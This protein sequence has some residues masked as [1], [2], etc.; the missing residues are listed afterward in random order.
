VVVR[1]RCVWTAAVWVAL[2]TAAGVRVAAAAMQWPVVN[3]DEATLGL[4][5]WHIA[6][7]RQFP[8]FFY[9]QHY[10]GS[11]VAY[12]AAPVFWLAGPSPFGL[13][14]VTIA[15][16]L[17]FLAALWKLAAALYDRRVASISVWVLAFGSIPM[18]AGQLQADGHNAT[19]LLAV[20]VMFLA[21][22]LGRAPQHDLARF[23]RRRWMW[24]GWGLVAGFGLW[25]DLLLV[26]FLGAA[27]LVLLAC[28]RSGGRSRVGWAVGG[29]L[30]GIGPVIGHSLLG[31]GA[32]TVDEVLG[33]V[34]GQA[35][36]RP[37]PSLSGRLWGAV[38]VSLPMATGASALCTDGIAPVWRTPAL[39]DIPARQC[40]HVYGVW[41]L[42]VLVLLLAALW[43]AARGAW[44][45]A[46]RGAMRDDPRLWADAAARLAVIGAAVATLA[47]YAVSS[48]AG[49]S[50]HAGSRYLQ[51]TWVG[52]PAV[53]AACISRG[54]ASAAG[55]ERN[56]RRLGVTVPRS[57]VGVVLCG[58]LLLGTG[59]LLSYAGQ[60]HPRLLQQEALR[61]GLLNA[62]VTRLYTDYW[63][64]NAL[65]FTSRE[66]IICAV[67]DD[68][69]T[70]G[71][72]R[73]RSYPAQVARAPG[74]WYVFRHD[75]AAATLL[76]RDA[77]IRRV[78]DIAGYAVFRGPGPGRGNPGVA[79]DRA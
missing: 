38:S 65:A 45:E 18:L 14:L 12:A 67:L 47:I 63:T 53:V 71:F 62:G 33:M 10:M 35:D 55:R 31:S 32:A 76:A 13:R 11:L 70:T 30:L 54:S 69:L 22:T 25:T 4:M 15:L 29:L 23:R 2:A 64:C 56:L 17:A 74:A 59:Q 24:G 60:P 1:G 50:P 8:V 72:D 16:F 36:P 46:R 28:C 19:R 61:D 44:G 6:E 9:G 79:S 49:A 34:S 37:E 57:L 68:D 40:A 75:S 58:T 51:A 41:G 26:P 5:A 7:G 3:S 42:A 21:V 66:R 78:A 73:L 48:P 20:L 27:V 52:L 43:T 39:L 77:A